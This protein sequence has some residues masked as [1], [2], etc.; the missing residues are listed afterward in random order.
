M[1]DST[2]GHQ[3]ASL[4]TIRSK[5][6]ELLASAAKYDALAEKAR[7][8]A[9]DYEAAERVWLKLFPQEAESYHVVPRSSLP[10]DD[11]AEAQTI[12]R[13]PLNVP[14]VPDMIITALTEAD[15]RPLSPNAL[16]TFVQTRYWPEARTADV[17][18]TAWR[19]WKDGRLTRPAQGLYALSNGKVS[20]PDP[21]TAGRDTN[22]G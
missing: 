22:R 10:V 18:S 19:M 16:L 7:K 21:L 13:K 11:L 8:E 12:L 5:R 14:S 9:A 17:G 3:P 4:Q 6:N 1:D 20:H 2:P 15:G